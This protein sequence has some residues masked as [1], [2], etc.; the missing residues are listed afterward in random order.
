M[1]GVRAE[2]CGC[3][4]WSRRQERIARTTTRRKIRNPYVRGWQIAVVI[5]LTVA[6]AALV[7]LALVNAP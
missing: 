2:L 1:P 6:V 3:D 5:V 4:S 7:I